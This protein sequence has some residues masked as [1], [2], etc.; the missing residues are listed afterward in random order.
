[1][2]AGTLVPETL[3]MIARLFRAVQRLPALAEDV[4][5]LRSELDRERSSGELSQ[6]LCQAF[7]R[8]RATA[9][10]TAAYGEAAPLVSVCVGTY[11]RSELLVRRCLRSLIAQTYRNLQIIVV[12]D[13]CT[14]DTERNVASLRDSRITFVNLPERGPYPEDPRLRWMVAGTMPI[15]HALALSTGSFIT[16]LDDDDEHPPERV[17]KLVRFIQQTRADLVFHPFHWQTKQ[18][19]WRRNDA[20][21]FGHGQVTTSALFYH[22]WLKRLPWDINAYRYREPG[23]WNRCR[24]IIYLEATTRRFPEPLLKHYAEKANAPR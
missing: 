14:D 24:K 21:E 13:A 7:L 3:R 11:N 5:W 6:E 19:A 10:Y 20:T 23:D 22:A 17:G 15:N 1:M 9:E 12:G 18:G 2:I 16:H 8:D 4:D